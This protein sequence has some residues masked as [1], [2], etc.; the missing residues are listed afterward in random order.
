M[1]TSLTLSLVL[2]ATL[3]RAADDPEA[4]CRSRLRNLG[5]AISAYRL[6]HEN[7]PPAKL[8][9]LY[10][11]GLV[12]S[13]DDF[14]CPASG[15]S[16]K[17]D[18][19]IDAKSDYTLEPV[20]GA[21]DMFVREK[22]ARHG[23]AALAIFAD[24][25]I[26]PVGTTSGAAPSSSQPAV[27]QATASPSAASPSPSPP[28]VVQA[29]AS[30][31]AASPSPSPPA[32]AQ[33]TASP[34]LPSPSPSPP[35]DKAPAPTTA[36]RSEVQQIATHVF[37]FDE[38]PVGPLP[39]DAFASAGIRFRKG[40]G[41][42]AIRAAEPNMLL[43]APHAKVLLVGGGPVNAFTILLDPPVKHFALFRVGASNGAST[44]TWKMTAYNGAG[45]IVGSTGEEHKIAPAAAPFSIEAA[46][47]G[48][49][50][51]SADNRQGSGT[52]ATWNS[53][54]IVGVGFDR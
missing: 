51:I 49:V 21:K 46:D 47:I 27:A 43:P 3:A 9:D 39:G 40:K 19:E 53:L 35:S 16:I 32:V 11:D 18:S 45:K 10:L 13:L 6:I 1:K 50:E 52:W 31:R 5:G 14:V 44:P 7:K 42:P 30:P 24:G 54:P 17:T 8:S 26:K 29:T 12:T 25:S 22:M 37:T 28:A 20:A 36:Y 34:S 2:V 41:E 33:T 38:L 15:S 4:G 48:R 23:A